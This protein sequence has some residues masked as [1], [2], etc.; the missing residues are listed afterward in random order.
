MSSMATCVRAE[1]QGVTHSR[2]WPIQKEFSSKET[3]FPDL[4]VCQS[5]FGQ[6]DVLQEQGPVFCGDKRWVHDVHLKGE[7][8]QQGLPLQQEI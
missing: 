7:K 4:E 1:V 2:V 8:S 5:G 3:I 6:S